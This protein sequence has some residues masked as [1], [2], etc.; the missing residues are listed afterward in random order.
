MEFSQS[1]QEV[2]AYTKKTNS[3]KKNKENKLK[4]QKKGRKC[5]AFLVYLFFNLIRRGEY[6]CLTKSPP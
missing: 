3:W 6:F 2:V 1:F 4:S 5:F